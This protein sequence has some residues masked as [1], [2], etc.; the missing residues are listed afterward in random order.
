MK[1]FDVKSFVA[2]IIIGTM[3]ITTVFAATGIQSAVLSDAKV[4]LNGESLPLGKPLI[5]VTMDH[6]QNAGL[7][8]PANELL[9]K[10]GYTVNY[11]GEKNTVDLIYGNGSP[12]GMVGGIMSEGDAVMDLSNHANQT[13]IAESG[14]FQAEDNQTLTLDITSDIRGGSVDLFFFNPNGEEE[15]HIT[16]GFEDVTVTREIPLTRGIWRYNCSGVF[17]DGG[18]IR[19]VGTIK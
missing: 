8:L 5:S 10:L 2:G 12:H 18:N 14:S 17:K 19:I 16:I 1:K 15:Q 3:G 7:Y 9:E 13:N 6:E 11:D 4:T